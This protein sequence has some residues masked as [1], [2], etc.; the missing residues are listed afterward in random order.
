MKKTRKLLSVLLSAGIMASL[1]PGAAAEDT[2][3]SYFWS[4]DGLSAPKDV[5]HAS[6]DD[7]GETAVVTDPG[8]SGAAGDNSYGTHASAYRRPGVTELKS[9]PRINFLSD[10]LSDST[11]LAGKTIVVSVD[12]MR[13]SD[14]ARGYVICPL[15]GEARWND[16][17][18]IRIRDDGCLT[19]TGSTNYQD[20]CISE[21]IQPGRW[22][23]VAVKYTFDAA[24]NHP[25]ADVYVN[26]ELML[27]DIY[28]KYQKTLPIAFRTACLASTDSKWNSTDG[29]TR[30][31][32]R[33]ETLYIDNLYIG[34]DLTRVDYELGIS[35]VTENPTDKKQLT[36]R[37]NRDAAKAAYENDMFLLSLTSG[38]AGPNVTGSVWTDDKTVVLTLDSEIEPAV[39]YYIST[40]S[41]AAAGKNAYAYKTKLEYFWSMD[42]TE[43]T[44]PKYFEKN[45]QDIARKYEQGRY[46]TDGKDFDFKWCTAVGSARHNGIDTSK[47]K[48][49]NGYNILN[50]KLG[51]FKT[52]VINVNMDF[53]LENPD[54]CGF[55]IAPRRDGAFPNFILLDNLKLFAGE[56]EI[57]T[58]E[59]KKW[60][61]ISAV[62]HFVTGGVV[63]DVYL[64][65]ELKVEAL[66]NSYKNGITGIS[67]LITANTSDE[68]FAISPRPDG[69]G[70]YFHIDNLYISADETYT[71][72]AFEYSFAGDAAA[73]SGGAIG[74][75]GIVAAARYGADGK[76]KSIK[77]YDMKL[78]R[79]EKA[80]Y[81]VS[82]GT[83]E[84]ND[85]IKYFIWNGASDMI[86]AINP[87]V[88]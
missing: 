41:D 83:A 20:N 63:T 78:D 61:N 68:N 86:P 77:L 47:I 9:A 81:D 73:V 17:L 32:E 22:Y 64:D 70:E 25:S 69:R 26:G 40:L 39:T 2:G 80:A 16:F 19:C 76:L 79:T 27:D 65:G 14:G 42:E 74:K 36:L 18:G 82:L 88:K 28:Y 87:V 51:T 21:Y 75:S 62:Y 60:Y 59:P 48:Y 37:Y 54:L 7:A 30:A 13:K 66:Y 4:F 38:A 85:V 6:F 5:A 3:F 12:F 71:N 84:E 33:D 11:V 45:N 15:Y 53:M 31:Y 46:D 55:I 67:S 29:L 52:G 72:S 56:T 50:G 24:D 44:Y 58:I 43:N 49:M 23:N 35:R 8:A 57:G 34:D 10:V 1:I